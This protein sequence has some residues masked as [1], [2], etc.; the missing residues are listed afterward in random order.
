M[1]Y[2]DARQGKLADNL[3][4]F[5]R[6]LRRAGLRIDASRLMLAQQAALLVGVERRDDLQAALAAVLVEREQDRAVFAEMFDAWFRNPEVAQKLLAQLLPRAE[7]RAAP[8][9]RQ[10]P[11]VREALAPQ[12]AFGQPPGAQKPADTPVEFDAAMTA[13]DLE[14]L[15]HADFNQ[16]SASEY[17]LVQRL[18]ADLRLDMP[19][20]R[21]RRSRATLQPAS[22]PD[23]L[24]SLRRAA[25][26]GGEIAELLWRKPLRE[27]LPLVVL[28]DVS[29]SM[30]R[31]ARLLLA[32][33]HN[34]TRGLRRR[35]VFAFGTRLTD[36]RPAFALADS[37]A[38]LRAAGAAID[39][40]AGGTRLGE[41]LAALQREHGRC[42]VGGRSLL[43]LVSDGLDTGSPEQLEAELQ[44]LKRRIGSLV[45]L[46]P[47]LRFDGY[48]PLARG[49]AVLARHA[50]AMLA[51]HNVEK[52]EQLAGAL[53]RLL[54]A[55]ARVR[56]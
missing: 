39:D 53:Q 40:F 14:R 43:L 50:D 29:G 48:A 11:R 31:Y 18:V 51:V 17:A 2:G 21:A 52:L 30:E 28:V 4:A 1:L 34:A 9:A 33:V 6:A 16:L 26:H 20:V 3:S 10:R 12:R 23:A 45:W 54:K 27:P 19:T 22:A 44:A 25:R 47:L 41:A 35:A 38:M 32:F 24:R 7:G 5:G 37:D 55:A 13:G 56:R 42:L 8:P 46:N 36:L 49:A 15:K